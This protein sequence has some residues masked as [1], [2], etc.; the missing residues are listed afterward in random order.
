MLHEAEFQK[1]SAKT[2]GLK[3]TIIIFT[4]YYIWFPT[5]FQQEIGQYTLPS[6]NIMMTEIEN[7]QVGLP[8]SQL[9]SI[10]LE[11]SINSVWVWLDIFLSPFLSLS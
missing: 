8:T 6:V 10:C 11:H 2:V 7:F 5:I 3:V 9:L 1:S 4:H